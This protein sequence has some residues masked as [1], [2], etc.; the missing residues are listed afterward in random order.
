MNEFTVDL[1][2]FREAELVFSFSNFLYNVAEMAITH[3]MI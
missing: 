1:S 2:I 3:E